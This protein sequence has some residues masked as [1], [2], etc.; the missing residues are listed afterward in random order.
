MINGTPPFL[1]DSQISQLVEIMKVLGTPPKEDIQHMN[2]DYDINQYD[3]F[4]HVKAAQWKNLLRTK[5]S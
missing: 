5:D 4:P 2:K 1:G 3:K